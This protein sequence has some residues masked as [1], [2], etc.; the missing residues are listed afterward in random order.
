MTIVRHSKAAAI[1][2]GGLSLALMSGGTAYA[3]WTTSGT[4][5]GT[6]SAGT[7]TAI[8]AAPA[9]VA[10]GLYPGA[11][12]VA[13]TV[14]VS[15]PNPFPVQVTAASFATPTA[16]GG[17]GTCTSTGVTFTAQS[18]TTPVTVP[19]K[20]G[21]TNGT[22]PLSFTAAMSNASDNGCQGATFTST[23]TLTGQS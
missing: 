3:Y 21:T 4:G 5:T 17:L 20:V 22:A 11:T 13:G 8:S 2:I 6:A 10:S 14:T 9:T 16:A 12:G 19:A 15:N 18:L 1:L 23:V 7:A